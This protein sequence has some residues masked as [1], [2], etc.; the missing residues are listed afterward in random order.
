M[1]GNGN[2]TPGQKAAGLFAFYSPRPPLWRLT[3]EM[4]FVMPEDLANGIEQGQSTTSRC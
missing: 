4:G 1:G 3:K 2:G